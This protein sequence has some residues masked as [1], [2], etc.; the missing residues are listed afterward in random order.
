MPR[1]PY[2]LMHSLHGSLSSCGFLGNHWTPLMS[3]VPSPQP[4]SS[5]G[6][7]SFP[8]GFFS[9]FGLG[10][11]GR[12]GKNWG[13]FQWKDW[14]CNK[15]PGGFQLS[16][17][18]L[19][20]IVLGHRWASTAN[21]A[22]FL[23]SL[24]TMFQQK[25]MAWKVGTAIDHQLFFMVQCGCSSIGGNLGK[26]H[27]FNNQAAIMHE[28]IKHHQLALKLLC[29]ECMVECYAAVSCHTS[30]WFN[31]SLVLLALPSTVPNAVL[32]DRYQYPKKDAGSPPNLKNLG[33][34]TKLCW[35]SNPSLLLFICSQPLL[36]LPLL[37]V[38]TLLVVKMLAQ[39]AFLTCLTSSKHSKCQKD[40]NNAGRH[41]MCLMKCAMC[42]KNQ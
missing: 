15:G 14:N 31:S 22:F 28:T 12:L 40:W 7:G 18:L 39:I 36:L 25:T 23:P 27:P 9:A 20:G 42:T 35:P 2:R 17:W 11:F 37:P 30:G 33:K 4:W 19:I 41:L 34:K 3:D 24:Q 38:A 8:C 29:L 26:C 13:V 5:G 21:L 32:F 6:K 10:F 1:L 16:S